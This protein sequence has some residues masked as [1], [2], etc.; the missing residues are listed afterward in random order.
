MSPREK[1]ED[2]LSN[3]FFAISDPT[4]RR[5]LELLLETDLYPNEKKPETSLEKS[6]DDDQKDKSK[7][8]F[9]NG[10]VPFRIMFRAARKAG[11]STFTWQGSL[12]NT[13]LKKTNITQ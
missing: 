3:I 9:Q 13:K 8:S 5:I 6:I 12:Y 11:I 2:H 7:V 10:Y 1:R 4:R